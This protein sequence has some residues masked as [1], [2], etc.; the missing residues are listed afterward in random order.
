[1]SDKLKTFL[2]RLFSTIISLAVVAAVCILYDGICLQMLVPLLCN[3]AAVEWFFMLRKSNAGENRW[4]VML[5]GGDISVVP[6]HV[7]PFCLPPRG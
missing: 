6:L 1:M 4:L 2:K 7:N 5:G 3:L